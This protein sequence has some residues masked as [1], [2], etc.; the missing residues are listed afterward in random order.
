MFNKVD[1]PFLLASSLSLAASVSLWFLVNRDYGVFVGLWVPSILILWVG[2][3]VVLLTKVDQP[4]QESKP[5]IDYLFP[6][7]GFGVVVT[8]I[9]VKGLIM[10]KDMADAQMALGKQAHAESDDDQVRGRSAPTPFAFK[11]AFALIYEKRKIEPFRFQ[12][13]QQRSAHPRGRRNRYRDDRNFT[14]VRVHHGRSLP[15]SCVRILGLRGRA[16][17]VRSSRLRGEDKILSRSPA[18]LTS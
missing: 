15:G 6:I 11:R 16:R 9:V 7:F 12:H 18:S 5:V 2:V 10:A 13:R 14:L 17:L 3:R 8:G 4:S 1:R